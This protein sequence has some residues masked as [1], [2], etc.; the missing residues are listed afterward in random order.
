MGLVAIFLCLGL[1]GCDN[2][3][4]VFG[5]N[6]SNSGG[7][8]AQGLGEGPALLPEAGEWVDSAAP[9]VQ[10]VTPSGSGADPETP[11]VVVFSESMQPGATSAAFQLFP[12]GSPVAVDLGPTVLLATGRVVILRPNMPLDPGVTYEVRHSMVV[13]PAD[14]NGQQLTRPN[15]EIAGTFT[16]ANTAP[17]TPA[18]LTTFPPAGATFQSHVP[19]V[20]V[21]FTR[22]VDELTVDGDSFVVTVDTVAPAFDPAPEPLIIQDLFPV[23]DTRV[24][25]WQSLDGASEPAPLARGGMFELVLSPNPVIDGNKIEDADGN[26]VPETTV[27]FEIA[28]FGLTASTILSAPT[29][30]INI[31]NLLGPGVLNVEVT[32]EDVEA[33]DTIDVFL[34]GF[35]FGPDPMQPPTLASLFRTVPVGVTSMPGI[36]VAVNIGAA[37]L[38]LVATTSPL[39]TR[40][41][42]GPVGFAFRLRR[43]TS[44]GPVQLLDVDPL[45]AGL[46]SPVIDTIPPALL[47]LGPTGMN[48]ASQ[49]SNV[50]DLVVVGR[51]TEPVRAAFVSAVGLGDNGPDPMDPPPVAG[52]DP[53]GLFIARPVTVADGVIPPASLPVSFTVTIFDRALNPAPLPTVALYNQLGVSGPDPI[54]A[55]QVTVVL[56]D[57]STKAFVS[58]GRVFTHADDGV[59]TVLLDEQLA[60]ADGSALLDATL[61]PG[62]ELIVTVDA[63]GYDLFTFHGAVADR[64]GIPLE[65]T[66]LADGRVN[67]NVTSP[68]SLAATTRNV[69]DSRFPESSARLAGVAGCSFS[70]QSQ[71]FEC[72]FGPEF[73]AARDVGAQS[74]LATTLPANEAQYSA[75]TFMIGFELLLPALPAD[76]GVTESTTIDFPFLMNDLGLDFEE[77]AIDVSV[78]TLDTSNQPGGAGVPAITL[79]ALAPG[80]PGAVS[81]G[82]GVAFPEVAAEMWRVRSAYPGA[83]DPFLSGGGDLL[84]RYVESGA[85]EADIFLRA[86]QT[87]GAGNRG[88]ARPRLSV[89]PGSLVPPAAAVLTAPAPGGNSLAATYDIVFTDILADGAGGAEGLYRVRLVGANGRAWTLY[90]TDP[91]DPAATVRV[92]VP[93]L[94]PMGT[95][96][97]DGTIRCTLSA[98]AWPGL[99]LTRFLWTDLEREPTRASHSIEFT[100][101]QP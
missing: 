75:F 52:S 44:F 34:F 4:C 39:T 64:I 66:S 98:Y 88:I 14:L 36:P 59:G 78:H 81:V 60:A 96:L 68:S 26:D 53:F 76:P 40:V 12:Q 24:F 46:Q 45:A 13:N 67:G 6:C 100:Y 20:V 15:D 86:E 16:V 19:E 65:L 22:P 43:G 61:M 69:S 72:P 27:A 73:V 95:A 77:T 38:D 89:T 58:G 10:S 92:K 31:E 94:T 11:I 7:N 90:R 84:G 42:D 79:E 87:D 9:F 25:L 47:G 57:A 54:A 74:A 91:P 99:D 62:E 37:A 30:A 23:T 49:T 21:V 80:V 41:I 1:G 17:S 3:A 48:L 82:A 35:Q 8:N 32:V 29:D 50:Q 70:S 93:D 101:S 28:P 33:A 63:A 71:L 83:V 18:L 55:S 97:P 2:P 85:I 5:G 56:F 51:A